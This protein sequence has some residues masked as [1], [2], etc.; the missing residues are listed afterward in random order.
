MGGWVGWAAADPARRTAWRRW[1]EPAWRGGVRGSWGRELVRKSGH[2]PAPASPPCSPPV[3][4]WTCPSEAPAQTPPPPDLPVSRPL[5]V[6]RPEGEG[7]GKGRGRERGES[8]TEGK[9]VQWGMRGPELGFCPGQVIPE[10]GCG[11]ESRV[12]GV[13]GFCKFDPAPGSSGWPQVSLPDLTAA[14]LCGC[15]LWATPPALLLQGPKEPSGLGRF[16]RRTEARAGANP[17][18]IGAKAVFAS[19]P[20]SSKEIQNKPPHL[21]GGHAAR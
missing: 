15:S 3:L 7:R 17:G 14:S 1:R 20:S 18:T 8:G 13:R 16:H 2:A 10:N 5:C 19:L 4:T 11:G 12:S 6:H 21:F 9:R